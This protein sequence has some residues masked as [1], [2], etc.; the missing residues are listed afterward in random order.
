[1]TK[2]TDSQYPFW[3]A[4][5]TNDGRHP[6]PGGP[7]SHLLTLWMD[8]NK[9]FHYFY[10]RWVSAY[11]DEAE[12]SSRWGEVRVCGEKAEQMVRD[13]ASSLYRDNLHATA[14]AAAKG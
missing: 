14:V 2:I 11:Y 3:T 12:A 5:L 1:M 10:G 7:N 8:R 4:C 13:Y 9:G 6:K